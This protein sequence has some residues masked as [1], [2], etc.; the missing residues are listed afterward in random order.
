MLHNKCLI[1]SLLGFTITNLLTNITIHK[2]IASEGIES[3]NNIVVVKL[4]FWYLYC[5]TF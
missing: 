3:T 4:L 2:V 5:V 1:S